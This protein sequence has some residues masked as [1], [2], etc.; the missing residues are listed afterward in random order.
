VS[1]SVK[2]FSLAPPF[3]L[4]PVK[5]L[6][7]VALLW[8]GIYLPGLGTLQL[9]HEEPRR[10]L[11]GLHMLASGDWLVP[12]VGSDP[13]LRKPPLLNWAIALS[14]KLSG[15]PS[16]WAV[17]LPSV[18]ATLALALTIV[19]VAGG[20]W[21]GQEGGLIAAIFFLVNFTMVESGRLAELEALYVSFTGIALILWM[22][23]WHQE[24][25]PWQLWLSPAP[26]LALG[27]LTKGPTH[28]VFYYGV[29]LPVLLFGK[30]ARSLLHPAHWL[31]L[32]L[33]IGALLCWAIPC[34][35]AVGDHNPVAVWHFW[36][37]QLASRASTESSQHFHL[38]AWLLN[39]PQTLKNFLPWTLL[40]PLLWRKEL[41][42]LAGLPASSNSRELALFRGAR[43]GMLATAVLMI[44]LPNGSPRY[45][46]PLIVV[47][48]LLLGRALT[49]ADSSSNPD[50]LVLAW[51]RFN[52]LLLT[53]VSL[54]VAVAPFFARGE[55]KLLFWICLQGVLAAAIWLFALA[56]RARVPSFPP[57]H[58]CRLVA[59]AIL[60]GS[61][62]TLAVMF[63]A[64]M[65]MPRIDSSN[66]HR[67]REVA[68]AIRAGMA[69]G[70]QLWVQEDSYRPFWYYLEPNVRYFH[71]PADLPAQAHYFLLPTSETKIF[72]QDPIWQNAPPTWIKQV[73]DNENRA[74]DL[75]M[76]NA[77]LQEPGAR[78]Q[79][80]ANAPEDLRRNS[81]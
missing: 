55:R 10:A 59:Q 52:L 38:S 40:L 39:G 23:S 33:I 29:V 4:T 25:G 60:S 79:P 21:L 6:V 70:A 68:D 24:V 5:A 42:R 63:F 54:G 18:L 27:M 44:L 37:N 46:Y 36:W 78:S 26:F 7:F 22:T 74:F 19:G 77:N 31:S 41:A 65:I 20:R 17:R 30:D 45:L 34:S 57:S 28:L 15:G 2:S 50:W 58:S 53:T 62:T 1:F 35:L 81:T 16:E 56:N 61:V 80:R 72:L 43:W 32:A 67:S 71:H 14:C 13:Y 75:F 64:T 48:C 51:H 76:R 47:P 8:V 66:R 73:I 3:R 9:Q 11:P 12:R 69:A 49:V